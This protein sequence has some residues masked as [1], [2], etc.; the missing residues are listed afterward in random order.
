[1][2]KTKEGFTS[3]LHRFLKQGAMTISGEQF[4]PIGNQ[5]QADR[6]RVLYQLI[7]EMTK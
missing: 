5:T 4:F 2:N 3:R 7:F 6:I 1:M